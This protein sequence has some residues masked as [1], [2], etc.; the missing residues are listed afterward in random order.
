MSE[1]GWYW[2]KYVG[3]ED[4]AEDMEEMANGGEESNKSRD[5]VFEDLALEKS[6]YKVD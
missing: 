6:S 1:C 5:R 2:Q 3:W 4:M